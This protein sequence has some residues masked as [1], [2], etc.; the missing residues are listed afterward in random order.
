MHVGIGSLDSQVKIYYMHI[1]TNQKMKKASTNSYKQIETNECT[2]GTCMTR[3]KNLHTSSCPARCCSMKVLSQAHISPPH[4][5]TSTT[6]HSFVV[7]SKR[8]V[9]ISSSSSF[10]KASSRSPKK[11]RKSIVRKSGIRKKEKEG[12]SG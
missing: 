3:F 8:F 9:P 1:N 10:Q 7:Q 11:E 4:F 6:F 2:Q 5:P 12:L